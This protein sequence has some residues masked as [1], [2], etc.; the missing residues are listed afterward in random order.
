MMVYVIWGFS[1][2]AACNLLGRYFLTDN[3]GSVVMSH[4]ISGDAVTYKKLEN[5]K[6]PCP[7]RYSNVLI[8]HLAFSLPMTQ[9]KDLTRAGSTR[10]KPYKWARMAEIKEYL[11]DD[12]FK[13]SEDAHNA[14]RQDCLDIL[15]FRIET[16]VTSIL[17]LSL[18][19]IADKGFNGYKNSRKIYDSTGRIHCGFFGFEGNQDTVYFQISGCGCKFLFDKISP[20]SLHFWLYKVLSVRRLTRIDLAVDDMTGNF[21]CD[22][23][24]NAYFDDAFRVGKRGMMPEM[25]PQPHYRGHE[26]I[27]ETIYVG[28]RQSTFF[29]RIYDKAAEQSLAKTIWYRSECECKRVD[30]KVLLNIAAAWNG[31]NAFS[32]SFSVNSKESMSIRTQTQRACL[33]LAGRIQWARKQVGRT[34]SDILEHFDGDLMQTLGCLI[35]ERGGKFGLPDSYQNLIINHLN[36]GVSHVAS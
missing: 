15:M 17:G 32:A 20:P 27:S 19:P 33:D 31:F 34:L 28:S 35:D 26:L 29:W 13:N 24:K 23:A 22:Y 16:F 10:G 2:N 3:N 11:S 25:S 30:I 4:P 9:F 5:F 36:N 18:G 6:N 12:K 1:M 8:D 7:D 14:F 21:D